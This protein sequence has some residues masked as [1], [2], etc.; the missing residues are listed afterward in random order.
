M[1]A[2]KI[3]DES[4][5]VIL[6]GF[7]SVLEQQQFSITKTLAKMGTLDFQAAERCVGNVLCCANKSNDKGKCGTKIFL[8]IPW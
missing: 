3:K 6:Q 4:G 1:M 8:I 7:V 2:G 5:A